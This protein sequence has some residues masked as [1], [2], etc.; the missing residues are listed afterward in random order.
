M[1]T[2]IKFTDEPLCKVEVVSDF[3]LLPAGLAFREEGAILSLALSEKSIDFFESKV[4]GQRVRAH[5]AVEQFQEMEAPIAALKVMALG[6]K[7][8]LQGTG[9]SFR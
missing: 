9:G 3:L 1:S 6:E 2:K 5:K 8:R 4:G 7:D